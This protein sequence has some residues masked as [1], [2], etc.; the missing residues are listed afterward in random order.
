MSNLESDNEALW[1]VISFPLFVLFGILGFGSP[2][3]FSAVS[4]ESLKDVGKGSK[5]LEE[6]MVRQL[7]QNNLGPAEMLLPLIS[8]VE[9]RIPARTISSGMTP[10]IEISGGGSIFDLLAFKTYFGG[11][12]ELIRP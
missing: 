1:R 6:E 4:D 11:L 2:V 7:R 9:K 12:D 10:E 5:T 3:F 8:S